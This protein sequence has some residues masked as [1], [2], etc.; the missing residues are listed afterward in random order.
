MGIGAGRAR[1]LVIIYPVLNL[2]EWCVW[3]ELNLRPRHY[4]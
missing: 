1:D 3:Q 2:R 4:Q